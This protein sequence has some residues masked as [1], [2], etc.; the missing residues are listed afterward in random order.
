MRKIIVLLIRRSCVLIPSLIQKEHDR[1]E[2]FH[3]YYVY[4]RDLSQ[5][6]S[7]THSKSTYHKDPGNKLIF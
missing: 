6:R 5:K 3:E 7:A 1:N 4:D 2:G